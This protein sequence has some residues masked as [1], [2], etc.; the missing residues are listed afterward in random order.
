MEYK[1]RVKNK[2]TLISSELFEILEFL[3]TPM[4][5]SLAS[6]HSKVELTYTIRIDIKKSWIRTFIF[7]FILDSLTQIKIPTTQNSTIPINH[8]EK[9]S[10]PMASTTP[11][12][13]GLI[14]KTCELK[15][16]LFILF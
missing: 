10:N 7:H 4:L 11:S 14:Q 16:S 1:V 15:P 13:I 3:K 5:N 2:C 12:K 9:I 6:K 8:Y